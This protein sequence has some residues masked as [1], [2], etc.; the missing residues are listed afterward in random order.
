V[1]L[2][3]AVC[4]AAPARADESPFPTAQ[5]R[6]MNAEWVPYLD[7]PPKPAAICLVD[8][9]VNVTPDT[10]DYPAG[11]IVERVA[12]DGGSGEGGT[13]PEQ[14]HG[15]YMAMTAAA[16][17]NGWGTVGM[18]P[19]LRIV[20]IRARGASEAAFAYTRY[21]RAISA[22]AVEADRWG[23]VVTNLSL[24]CNCEPTADEAAS[25]QDVVE[26][27]HRSADMSVVASAGNSGAGI[28]NPASEP[29]VLSVGASDGT[30]SLCSF[31][32]R[33][34][35]G[36]IAEGCGL[37][38]SDPFSG[39][40][41]VGWAGGT[42]AAAAEVSA[43]LALLRSYR[44]DMRWDQAE[45]LLRESAVQSI[46]GPVMN[47]EQAFRSAGLG[48]LVDAAKRR[49]PT[50]SPPPAQAVEAPLETGVAATDPLS[51]EITGTTPADSGGRT[52]IPRVAR[53][54][55][56]NHSFTVRIRSRPAGAWLRLE[57]QM[58][59]GEFS[60]RTASTRQGARRAFRIPIPRHGRLRVVLRF[61][62]G[63]RHDKS[64]PGLYREIR[65]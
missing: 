21:Q 18:W 39:E 40:P 22:C 43:A 28:G 1:A 52:R 65:K 63:S 32:N 26:S 12:L 31:S 9:G 55:V 3:V 62:V 14:L 58:A 15:T 49:E 6:A 50:E 61:V 7:P 53:L 42:S 35:L 60:W 20:S 4:T 51:R 24:G 47:V 25:M 19:G 37:D 34:S 2:C 30:G 41:Y 46:A 5:A 13:S 16:P 11:P 45:S 38:G 29:G 23:A 36:L 56:G 57:L 44:P 48:A 59:T 33:G 64:L 10:L 17:I 54:V 8:T 27:A